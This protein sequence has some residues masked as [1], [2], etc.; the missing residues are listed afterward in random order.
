MLQ[1]SLSLARRI[2]RIR[3]HEK[4]PGSSF[5]GTFAFTILQFMQYAQAIRGRNFA[6][7]VKSPYR[8]Q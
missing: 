7:Y 8:R 5:T 3:I 2:Q 6:F 1:A 4:F